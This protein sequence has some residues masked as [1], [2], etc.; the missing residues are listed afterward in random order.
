V[1]LKGERPSRLRIAILCGAAFLAALWIVTFF[2]TGL[3]GSHPDR[4][5]DHRIPRPAPLVAG[6]PLQTESAP[7]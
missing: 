3:A 1:G 5:Y 6:D 7:R 4:L 2:A